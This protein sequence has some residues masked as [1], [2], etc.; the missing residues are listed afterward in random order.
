MEHRRYRK[1]CNIDNKIHIAYIIDESL[2]K[3]NYRLLKEIFIKL[4]DDNIHIHYY[5]EEDSDF[6]LR[7][8]IY[9]KK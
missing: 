6:N 2:Y 9:I 3:I 4:A 1:Y 8:N 7:V 5:I